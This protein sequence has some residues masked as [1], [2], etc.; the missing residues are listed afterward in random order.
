MDKSY[1][2]PPPTHISAMDESPGAVYPDIAD[3]SHAT[4][5][6]VEFFRH[7]F[8][9]KSRHDADTWMLDFDTSKITYI[10]TVL[11]LS[12]GPATFEATTRAIM[13]SWAGDAK[14]YPLRIIGDDESAVL[15]FEDTP[16]MFGTELRGVAA[17]DMEN[18]KVIRQ[19]DYWDGRRSPLAAT[20]AP[21]SQHPTDF[22]ESAVQQ[23]R[24]PN[25]VLQ[26]VV[27]KLHAALS[28]GDSSAAAVL[29]SVDA[30][31]EDRT[32]RTL[33]EGRPAIERY[34]ARAC[35]NL[36]Y[37]IGSTIRH[38][39]G[40]VQGGGYEWVGG[41]DAPARHGMTA[42]KLNESQQVIFINSVW[43]AS[44][45]SDKAMMELALLAIEP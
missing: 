22:G 9:A 17:V 32:T 34:L 26:G 27:K 39:V 18:G 45:A 14:S 33:I 24:S 36:P 8:E 21:G 10:D 44:Y 31:W 4:P 2:S 35:S 38:M 41:P 30:V 23:A 42:F 3:I 13:A 20:R 37:G 29:F 43:D 40:G 5:T 16:E 11:G 28:K 19:V 12:L 7:Y 1:H 6:A 25:A 15:F